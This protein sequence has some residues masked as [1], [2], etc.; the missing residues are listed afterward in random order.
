MCEN[1]AY[2]FLLRMAHLLIFIH[3]GGILK[4]T[5]HP[6]LK[7]STHFSC[8]KTLPKRYNVQLSHEML[9][10]AMVSDMPDGLILMCS[11]PLPQ[12]NCLLVVLVEK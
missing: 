4:G 2:C 10:N 9:R 5:I 12:E 3:N 8:Y 6:R 7:N 11:H 1:N